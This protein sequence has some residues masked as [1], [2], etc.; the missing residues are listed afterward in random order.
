MTTLGGRWPWVGPHHS[1]HFSW[2][3]AGRAGSSNIS[4]AGSSGR[5]CST[6][7]A[8][9]W[10]GRY[11]GLATNRRRESRIISE[12][13]DPRPCSGPVLRRFRPWDPRTQRRARSA[14]AFGQG[15][16]ARRKAHFHNSNVLLVFTNKIFVYIPRPGRCCRAR[17][18]HQGPSVGYGAVSSYTV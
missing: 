18:F 12:A 13:T 16:F 7:A 6:A 3:G 4:S 1:P 17:W 5:P 2:P 11:P 9:H 15:Q 10:I 14:R 8:R